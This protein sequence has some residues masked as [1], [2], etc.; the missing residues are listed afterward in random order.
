M[1]KDFDIAGDMINELF[2]DFDSND[3]DAGAA[4]GGALTAV[5]F[6]LF[7]SCPD[8]VTAMGMLS[9]AMGQAA[10]MTA[11]YEAEEDTKH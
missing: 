2:D 4:M 3:L 1:E 7:I 8:K 6:R 11:G 9:S 5:F 10:L